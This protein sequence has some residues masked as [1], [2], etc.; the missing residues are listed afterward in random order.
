MLEL[1]ESLSAMERRILAG[2]IEADQRTP[3]PID[4]LWGVY[5]TLPE[6]ARKTVASALDDVED[7]AR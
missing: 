1:V 7:D 5:R 3:E 4:K 2:W 6:E